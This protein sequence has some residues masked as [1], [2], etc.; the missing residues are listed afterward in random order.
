MAN[1]VD[2][3][4]NIL[5][6]N[7][8]CF[9]SAD[10]N[11]EK[12]DLPLENGK[13]GILN[14]KA[15]TT[16]ETT[17]DLDF[18]FTIDCS[19][20]MSDDCSDDRTKMQHT[21]HTLKNMIRFLHL[22]SS[23]NINITINSFNHKMHKI[24]ER[25]KI[26]DNNLDQLLDAVNTIVPKGITNIEQ[27]LKK[28][29]DYI[30]ELKYLYPNNDI[31]HIFMTDGEANTGSKDVTTLKHLVMNNIMNAFI[32]FGI[33]HDAALLNCLGAIDK[34]S[35]YFI[36]KLEHAG[37]IYGE[38]LHAVIY[39]VL[40]DCEIHISNGLIYDF[41]TNSWV[42]NFKI[43]DIVSE[44]QKTY[45][46]ISET[47]DEID[48]KIQ[49]T[50]DNLV[51]LYP[52]RKVNDADISKDIF[53]LRTL[54]LMYEANNYCN[55]I[56]THQINN[57]LSLIFMYE[58]ESLDNFRNEEQNLKK[59]FISFIIEMKK[60]MS[61]NS[62]TDDNF[63]KN[64]CD[65]IYICYRTFN[66]KHGKMFC[67]SRQTSQGS[68]RQYT[69]SNTAV[70]E[71][72]ETTDMFNDLSLRPRMYRRQTNMVSDFVFEDNNMDIDDLQ[73]IQH[74]VSDFNDAP[75]LTPQAT[76][77]MQ[78]VSREINDPQTSTEKL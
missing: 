60:F 47:P 63:M 43:G 41:K 32:G 45:N 14:F 62:L 76:Q 9:H 4:N 5:S 65:D 48:V 57:E 25:V 18:I 53:R 30:Q 6:Q 35:Y 49:G 13:L 36:D 74:N 72:E 28:T 69:V 17:K 54:Q 19:A 51:V 68:Q 39:K 77:V 31:N 2:F 40:V 58:N 29:S 64:L 78:F 52:S 15:V 16:S 56:K 24:V 61:D 10:I 71:N 3:T 42:S 27:A 73:N 37:F 50:M 26:S 59:K 11:N 7:T 12:I 38:I 1:L 67:S 44:A 20:S 55:K 34:S 66:T 46:I 22:H 33:Q 21:I 8:F 23:I 70:L 75:Y